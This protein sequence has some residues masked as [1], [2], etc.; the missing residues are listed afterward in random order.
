MRSERIGAAEGRD[1]VGLLHEELRRLPEKYRLPVVLCFLEGKSHVEAASQLGWPLG[2]VK[3]RLA[4]ARDLLKRR[5]ARRGVGLSVP[6]LV[7][8]LGRS[9]GATPPVALARSATQAALAFTSGYTLGPLS[10]TSL[11]LARDVL[12]T[13]RL[14]RFGIV[15]VLALGFLCGGAVLT[16]PPASEPRQAI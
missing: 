10:A 13:M 3:G 5:L 2:T 12:R 4:R 16:A 1:E 15:L 8:L 7:A 11:A 6:V 9:A 14:A